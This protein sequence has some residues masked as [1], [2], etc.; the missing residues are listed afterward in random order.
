MDGADQMTKTFKTLS[1]ADFL[2]MEPEEIGTALSRDEL[3]QL[4]FRIKALFATIANYRENSIT[5]DTI[6][7]LPKVELEQLGRRGQDIKRR[8]PFM[9]G[10]RCLS[11]IRYFEE[12]ICQKGRSPLRCCHRPK[13][14]I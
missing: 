4:A 13:S 9:P 7:A 1:G 2:K 14:R 6:A 11:F 8:S 10:S 5:F 12:Y 3:M